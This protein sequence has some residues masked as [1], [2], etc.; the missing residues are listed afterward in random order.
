MPTPLALGAAAGASAAIGPAFN[1]VVNAYRYALAPD[2]LQARTQSAGRMIA[3]GTIPLA[4]LVAGVLLA[5]I[6]STGTLLVLA[7]FMGAV[8]LVAS[9]LD[10]SWPRTE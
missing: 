1:V 2:H 10:L 8:A 7:A 6:G 4:P 5:A 9:L 3:W